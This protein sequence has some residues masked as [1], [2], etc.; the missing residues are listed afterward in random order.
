MSKKG[1]ISEYL[2]WVLIAVAVLVIIALAILVLGQDG[3]SLIDKF[4]ALV[5]G[6]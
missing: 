5:R 4:L 6:R 3:A 1:V 2:P